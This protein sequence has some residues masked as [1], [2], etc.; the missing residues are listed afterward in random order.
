MTKKVDRHKIFEK[1]NGHCAYCGCEI[2]FK[3]MQIDHYWPKRLDY[4]EPLVDPDREE[5]LMPSCRPCNIHKH[6]MRPEVWRKELERQ[7][8]M[9]LKNA[10]FKRAIRFGQIQITEKPI[11]FYFEK[12]GTV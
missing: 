1:F 11:V 7:V 3:N 12:K 10:Q 9:L 4:L 6:A 5:N 2:E 8:S